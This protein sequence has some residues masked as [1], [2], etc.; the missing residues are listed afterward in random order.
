MQQA[1][2]TDVGMGSMKTIQFDLVQLVN[3]HTPQ[4][5]I[6]QGSVFV[7]LWKCFDQQTDGPRP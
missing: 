2:D 3:S 1:E 4:I 7:G 6:M 5:V